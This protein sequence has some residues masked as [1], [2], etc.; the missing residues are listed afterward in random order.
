MMNSLQTQSP[1][2][3][4]WVPSAIPIDFIHDLDCIEDH[5]ARRILDAAV[6]VLEQ[7]GQLLRA[8]STP[9][10]TTKLPVVFNGSIGGHYRHC[11][12]H[13]LSIIHALD[14]D[15]VDYDARA[16]DRRLE[17]ELS[18]AL[19]STESLSEK[20]QILPSA[21]LSSPVRARCEVSYDHGN[22][23]VSPSSFGRELSNAIAHA[24]HHYALI[25]VMARLLGVELPAHF[26][27]A[28]STVAHQ[29]KQKLSA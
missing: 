28:P 25:A 20:L 22:S 29:A 15:L 13:F 21:T 2:R 27:I 24:I 5:D 10:Y 26:G 9:A 3:A 7:G 17:T 14:S 8:L 19:A 11:L 18:Y 1:Y 16:R 12:E 6:S 4:D 23:P